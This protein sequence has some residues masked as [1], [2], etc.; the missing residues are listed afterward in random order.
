MKDLIIG[1]RG[2]VGS[3]LARYFPDSMLAG[4]KEISELEGKS[5]GTIYCAAP[6][7]KKWW[8]NQNP[9]DDMAEIQSL[10]E[11]CQRLMCVDRF[12]LISTID[13]YDPPLNVNENS[14]LNPDS[15]PYGRHRYFLEQKIL[16]VF[17][18]KTKILR[19]PAL[20]G[21]GLKKNIIFDLLNNNNIQ[22]VN[23]NSAFQWFNLSFL[24]DIIDYVGTLDPCEILNVATEPVSTP[25]ILDRWFHNYKSQLD[26]DLRPINYDVHT[27][28]G[29][30]G[31][32]YLYSA[33]EV[34]DMHLNPFIQSAVSNR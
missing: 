3:H 10:I 29:L 6:Q 22:L 2:F 31:S 4:R 16:S 17:E 28:F 25:Q 27:I 8:A 5:F 34:L 13:V 32:S 7:A 14:N 9:E 21:S 23:P 30:K 18:E 33:D 15:H 1:C 20:V 26:W 11:A 24:P 12:V 19:L